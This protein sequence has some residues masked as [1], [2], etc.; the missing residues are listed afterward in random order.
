M[1][2]ML[3]HAENSAKRFG[4]VPSD[5]FKIHEV[6]DLSKM[7]IADWRHRALMHS[8]FGVHLLEKYIMGPTFKRESDGVELSTRTVATQ[9]IIEDLG[10]LLTPGEFLRE[11]PLRSWMAKVDTRTKARLQ[12]MSIAGTTEPA[13][14]EEVIT[15]YKYPDFKPE[16]N[17]LYLAKVAVKVEVCS[18]FSMYYIDGFW[19]H[20]NSVKDEVKPGPV[21]YWARRPIGPSM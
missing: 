18:T 6:L 16:Q 17:G 12:R 15:W 8:T 13:N 19:A 1:G 11:M 7:F 2:D 4:G 3:Q 14:I 9:H 21:L 20:S 10:V 5:Y